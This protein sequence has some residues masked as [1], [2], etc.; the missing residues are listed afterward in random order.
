MMSWRMCW[1]GW[2]SSNS[3]IPRFQDSKIPKIPKFQN[4][5]SNFKAK[6]VVGM[7]ILETFPM[8]ILFVLNPVSGGTSNDKAV[9]AIHA[10]A[11]ATR[12]DFKVHYTC[13]ENDLAELGRQIADYGPERVV[14]GGGDGTV[15]L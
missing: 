9:L 2:T 15:Q 13:G 14:A 6:V 8:K 5:K 11:V 4:S 10:L 3:K 1:N 12:C 7:V